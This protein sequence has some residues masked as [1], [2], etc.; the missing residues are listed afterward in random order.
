MKTKAMTASRTLWKSRVAS[1]PSISGIWPCAR[2][3]SMSKM[4]STASLRSKST[5]D[6]RPGGRTG[7]LKAK[8]LTRLEGSAKAPLGS[9]RGRKRRI[10][11]PSQ[12]TFDTEGEALEHPLTKSFQ[13]RNEA[14]KSLCSSVRRFRIATIKEKCKSDYPHA[15]QAL[16]KALDRAED[17]IRS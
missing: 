6:P 10:P 2:S 12:K 11:S 8:P 7:S 5:S 14:F 3:A 15:L 4:H 9:S 17:L 16:W 13:M 1:Y